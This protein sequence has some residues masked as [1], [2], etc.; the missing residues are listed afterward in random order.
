[1]V[2]ASSSIIDCWNTV[3]GGGA[4]NYVSLGVVVVDFEWVEVNETHAEAVTSQRL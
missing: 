3:G 1:M 2:C 4:F